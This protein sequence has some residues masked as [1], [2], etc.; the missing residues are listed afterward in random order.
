MRL[1][2]RGNEYDIKPMSY[3]GLRKLFTG[4]HIIDYSTEVIRKPKKYSMDQFYTGFGIISRI[5]RPLLRLI[6]LFI[7]N[8]NFILVK[9]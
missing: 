1:F 7:P 8:F 6:T 3:W 2:K 4:F 5:P 9:Q